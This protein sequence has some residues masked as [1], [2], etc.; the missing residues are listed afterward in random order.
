MG[1][2]AATIS[3]NDP[4][5]AAKKAERAAEKKAEKAAKKKAE[6]AAKKVVIGI[7]EERAK[8]E[9][10]GWLTVSEVAKMLRITPRRVR[11][12]LLK[13]RLPA[14]RVGRTWL[15]QRKDVLNFSQMERQPGRPVEN[16]KKK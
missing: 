8:I 6:I 15:I 4:I 2:S 14:M 11:D 5:V 10:A 16:E 3:T 9:L 1:I 7:A 13:G 12:F